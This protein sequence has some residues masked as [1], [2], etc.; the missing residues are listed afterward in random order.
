VEDNDDNGEA[1]DLG[2]NN[3]EV[4]TGSLGTGGSDYDGDSGDVFKFD[5]VEGF[6]VAFTVMFDNATGTL[7]GTIEDSEG[8]TIGQAFDFGDGELYVVTDDAIGP[9]DVAP[10]FLKLSSI[11][12]YT[13][14]RIS[15]GFS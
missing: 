3:F 5:A 10:F 4:F 6:S 9:N 13:D 7:D 12:N 11:S 2:G 15:R 8:D 14:Y 1:N